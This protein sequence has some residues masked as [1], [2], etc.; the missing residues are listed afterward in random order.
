MEEFSNTD[1]YAPVVIE[2]NAPV[3][4]AGDTEA[5]QIRN[6]YLSHEASV[7]SVGLL[8]L[9]GA[10]IGILLGLLYIVGGLIALGSSVGAA[11]AS[12]AF[13]FVFLA[14]IVAFAMSVFQLFL[15]LGL[16]RLTPWCRIGAI[17]LSCIGLI[18]IPIG[19]IIS[20]YILYLLLSKKGEFIFTDEYKRVIAA[21]PH[22]KYRTSIIVWIF[23]GL[24][25]F[26][27]ALGLV[28]LLLGS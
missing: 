6:M 22:I 2:D 20:G 27:L 23:L 26:L 8:Y 16:R 24:L 10:G 3:A 9:L 21:T 18:A 7:K 5:E 25:L 14:G 17:V 19:T 4:W 15:G 12:F 28:G 1:P 13:F 11:S